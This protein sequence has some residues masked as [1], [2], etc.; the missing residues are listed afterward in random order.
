MRGPSADADTARVAVRDVH[1]PA[2]IVSPC[3]ELASSRSSTGF[4]ASTRGRLVVLSVQ[5]FLSKVDRPTAE[6]DTERLRVVD[7]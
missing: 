3:S 6:A 2:V 1:V 7:R 4:P 5:R